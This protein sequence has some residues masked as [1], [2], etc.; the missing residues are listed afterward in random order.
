[1]H[2]MNYVLIIKFFT[3]EKISK[4]HIMVVI[5]VKKTQLKKGSI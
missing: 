2:S 1:M 3:L 5:D 4:L